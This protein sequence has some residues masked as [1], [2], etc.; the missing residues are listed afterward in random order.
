M[1]KRT[2]LN[3][4]EEAEAYNKLIE[5]FGYTQEETARRV[6]KTGRPSPTC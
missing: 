2:D 4:L 6:G 1:F 5:R 3:P